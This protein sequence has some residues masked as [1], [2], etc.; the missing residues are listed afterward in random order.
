[1]KFN[2]S[3]LIKY[4]LIKLMRIKDKR[5][6]VARGFAWGT[7]LAI[8]PSCPFNTALSF[9]APIFGGNIIAALLGAWIVGP[10]ITSPFWYWLSYIT[11]KWIFGL[12]G[13]EVSPLSY[14]RIES[15]LIKNFS[16]WDNTFSI[17]FTQNGILY[18][19]SKMSKYFWALEFGG[20]ILGLIGAIIAYKFIHKIENWFLNYKKNLKH[21]RIGSLNSSKLHSQKSD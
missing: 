3:R 5:E 4:Q 1:M 12:I 7:F 15:F 11:G 10:F 6:R 20:A 2:P 8:F 13:I 17:L 18:L 16:S 21:K 19:W 9:L 14:T